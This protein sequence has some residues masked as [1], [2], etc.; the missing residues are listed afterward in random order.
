MAEPALKRMTLD[1][2][3]VWEDGT[4]TRYELVGGFVIAM[5]PPA[6]NHGELAMR[7]GS[8]LSAAIAG[9][10]PCRVISEAGIVHPDRADSFFVSDLAMTCA[11]RGPRQQYVEAPIL[12]VEVLSPS[13]QVH[14]RGFKLPVYREM[15][16]VQEVLLVSSDA[17]YVELHRRSGEQ[18]ITEILHSEQHTI[19]LTSIGAEMPLSE[20][21]DGI[22]FD[23]Q[24]AG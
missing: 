11:P 5:A 19:R 6:A 4:D 23:E 20:L 8:R 7:V 14:D 18:W 15:E 16:T 9:R 13:T 24:L 3:L 21:Y 12:I 22:I 1:D 17:R 2:F 10:P